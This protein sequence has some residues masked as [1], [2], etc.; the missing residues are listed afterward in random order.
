MAN[1]ATRIVLALIVIALL[2][3]L[4]GLAAAEISGPA[5]VIDGDTIKIRGAKIRLLLRSATRS[6]DRGPAAHVPDLHR[7]ARRW[8][9]ISSA[10]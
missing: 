3:Q 8:I 4:P 6:F 5:K 2:T 10:I 7:E 9:H 1:L